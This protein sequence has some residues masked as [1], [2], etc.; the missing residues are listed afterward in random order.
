MFINFF[1]LLRENKVPVSITEYMALVESLDK[2]LI[3]SPMEFYY[4][5]RSLLVKDEKFFDIYDQVFLKYFNDVKIPIHI[6]DELIKW[7]N[8]PISLLKYKIPRQLLEYF[9]TLDPDELKRKLEM[10]MKKQQEEPDEES[11][12]IALQIPPDLYREIKG[13]LSD[14]TELMKR[15]IPAKLANFFGTTDPQELKKRLEELLR[16]QKEKHDGG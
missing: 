2:G 11:I 8:D 3:N 7:L 5:A 16:E 14:P 15:K 12:W 4:V 9:K 10:I 6:H 13:W 1:F